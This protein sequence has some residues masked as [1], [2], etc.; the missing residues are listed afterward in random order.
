MKELAKEVNMVF[1][2]ISRI[3]VTGDAV[4]YMSAARA[5]LRNIHNQLQKMEADKKEV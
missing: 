3:P 5:K 1:E 4:D 2:I